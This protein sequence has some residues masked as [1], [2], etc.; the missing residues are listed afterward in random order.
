MSACDRDK[1]VPPTNGQSLTIA[2]AR[3]RLALVY[4]DS[5]NPTATVKKAISTESYG[6]V[7]GGILDGDDVI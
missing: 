6:S 2:F 7:D 1:I 5:S 4:L 3:C